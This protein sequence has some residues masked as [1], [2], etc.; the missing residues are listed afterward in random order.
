MPSERL[1]SKIRQGGT[2]GTNGKMR[3]TEAGRVGKI[4]T[5]RQTPDKAPMRLIRK[6]RGFS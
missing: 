6:M 2:I 5:A 1:F 3:R 4:A